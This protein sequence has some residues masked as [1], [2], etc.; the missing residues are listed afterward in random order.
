MP[1]VT[2][3]TS[4]S[5]LASA[6]QYAA[7]NDL[8]LTIKEERNKSGDTVVYHL[9]TQS[10]A[11]RQIKNFFHHGTGKDQDRQ[12]KNAFLVLANKLR[13]EGELTAPQTIALYNFE[14]ELRDTH[15]SDL[16]GSRAVVWNRLLTDSFNHQN[17]QIPR[18][19]SKPEPTA[20]IGAIQNPTYDEGAGVGSVPVKTVAAD[21]EVPVSGHIEPYAV[22][23]ADDVQESD[24]GVT[25][26]YGN[27]AGNYE[28]P[29]KTVAANYEEPVKTVAAD[30]EEPVNTPVDYEQP[31]PQASVFTKSRTVSPKPKVE[32]YQVVDI[33][34]K[35]DTWAEDQSLLT[36]I[37]NELAQREVTQHFAAT[38]KAA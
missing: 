21:Y 8:H 1:E 15:T 11:A 22:V 3:V 16:K 35:V 31:V 23:H 29:V 37:R 2:A 9:K 17:T 18:S 7:E 13:N 10:N 26:G 28:E 27:V 36:V 14:S 34:S 4:F 20:G 6:V 30:Y 38:L 32:A 33:A 19:V 5:E 24:T 12:V 25:E